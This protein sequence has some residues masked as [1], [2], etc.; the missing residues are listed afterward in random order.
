MTTI[1]EM[2]SL[3]YE[4]GE[5]VGFDMPL[6]I[7]PYIDC[8]DSECSVFPAHEVAYGNIPSIYLCAMEAQS[9]RTIDDDKDTIVEH[10]Y[11]WIVDNEPILDR[12]KV[13]CITSPAFK[14]GGKENNFVKKCRRK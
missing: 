13:L 9:S 8:A 6:I 1:E 7:E 3:L 12:Q 14:Y 4:A 5:K 2:I 10:D 11:D